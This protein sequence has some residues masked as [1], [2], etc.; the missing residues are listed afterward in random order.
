MAFMN[1]KEVEYLINLYQSER[2]ENHLSIIILSRVTVIDI[3]VTTP[4][5]LVVVVSQSNRNCDIGF[6]GLAH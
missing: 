1:D 5:F 6:I 3:L 4:I 2:L